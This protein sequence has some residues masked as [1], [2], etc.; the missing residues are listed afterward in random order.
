MGK[1][2]MKQMAKIKTYSKSS[3]I[4][5]ISYN[6]S[7]WVI[8]DNMSTKLYWTLWNHGFQFMAQY[9]MISTK[10]TETIL[11]ILSKRLEL[12]LHHISI[13][14]CSSNN[15]KPS[16]IRFSPTF[17]LMKRPKWAKYNDWYY[18]GYKSMLMTNKIF[19]IIERLVSAPIFFLN[20]NIF[21]WIRQGT[22][23]R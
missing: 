19:E 2:Q 1:Q 20:K 11:A 23:L 22:S 9:I 17:E 16:R 6:L 18:S 13:N 14:P 5:S 7:G 8:L 21:I 12:E 4:L 15:I 3:C 10:C